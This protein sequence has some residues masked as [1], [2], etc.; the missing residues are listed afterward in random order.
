MAA[1][2]GT[3]D[4]NDR[5]N[6]RGGDPLP[7]RVFQDDFR[8]GRGNALQAAVA[9]VF[10][11]DLASV[12]NFAELPGGYEAAVRD[13]C[14]DRGRACTKTRLPAGTSGGG[15]LCVLRGKSPRGDFG[16]VVVARRNG[17]ASG[18]FEM[19]H[20]PHPDGAF[21]DESEA[22]GWCMVFGPVGGGE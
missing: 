3:N 10:G 13:F 11:L 5:G 15:G 7:R 17:R 21:L 18:G 20:D 16:H 6:E 19:L 14:R 12:P 1:V 4:A 9:S 8:P 22:F 2:S